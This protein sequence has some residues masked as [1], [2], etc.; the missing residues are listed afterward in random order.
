ML[1]ARRVTIRLLSVAA[2][3]LILIFY[4]SSGISPH[5]LSAQAV[6]GVQNMH[7]GF[8]RCDNPGTGTMRTWWNSSP[9]WYVGIYIGGSNRACA[10]ADL[11]ASWVTDA[12][13][14]GQNWSFIPIYVGLQD[15]CSGYANT[16]STNSTNARNEGSNAADYAISDAQNLGFTDSI[17]YFDLE[18]WG[19]TGGTCLSSAEAFVSGW[20]TEL[21]NRGWTAG[22][23]GSAGGSAMD[24]MYHLTNRPTDAFIADYSHAWN[25]PWG[26]SS[27][28]NS[29]WEFD[30]RIHQYNADST[31]E[32]HGG[33]C[34]KV[35]RNCAI[36][37]T[38]KAWAFTTEA[39]EPAGSSESDGPSEDVPPCGS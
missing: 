4:P 22:L 31:C 32:T 1:V 29:D 38:G 23:Y 8:D 33:I 9:Y 19:G 7:Q 24:D 20:A 27:V 13:S 28:P 36:G 37:K 34:L 10:N 14:N 15:P 39:S 11:T 30:H 6:I 35:D 12:N 18:S 3:V 25:S 17:I 5:R 2:L 26:I 21:Q 16:F